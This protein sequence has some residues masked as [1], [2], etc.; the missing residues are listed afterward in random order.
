MYNYNINRW[1]CSVN[2]KDIGILYGISAIWG[3][4]VGFGYSLLIRWELMASGK[5]ILTSGELYNTIITLLGLVM[6]FF[7][8]MRFLIGFLGNY[9]TRLMVGGIDMSLRRLNNISY[10]LWVFSFLLL[11]ISSSIDYGRNGGWTL[12]VRLST[13]EYSSSTSVDV[14]I[15]SILLSGISSLLGAVNFITTITNNRLKNMELYDV[16]I[17]VWCMYITNILL[18]LALPALAVGVTFILTDRNLNTQFYTEDPVLY[19]LLFWLFGLPEVY[20]HTILSI[21]CC[22]VSR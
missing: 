6:I 2:A 15:F 8:V 17:M 5:V 11:I 22:V 20:Q 4:L 1:I 21:Y 12:Y 10:W 14:L 13:I 19:Q 18:L 7:F 3:G 9:L 16:S